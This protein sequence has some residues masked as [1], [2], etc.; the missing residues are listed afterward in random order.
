MSQKI[1]LVFTW[2]NGLDQDWN[3]QRNYY[4][5]LN[6]EKITYY[7]QNSDI[8]YQQIDELNYAIS[9]A[10]KYI[11]W[12][13]NIY[14]VTANQTPDFLD[15][16]NPRIRIVDHTEIIPSEYLPTFSSG[17]IEANIWRISGLSE[18]F[19]YANDDF[20]FLRNVRKSY[21]LTKNNVLRLN[22]QPI[23]LLKLTSSKERTHFQNVIQTE[24]FLKDNEFRSNLYPCHVTQIWRKNTCEYI[25]DNFTD[26]TH[27][28][29]NPKFRTNEQTFWSMIVYNIEATRNKPQIRFSPTYQWVVDSLNSRANAIIGLTLLR[30]FRPPLACINNMPQSVSKILEKKFQYLLN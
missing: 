26:I 20:L 19:L 4:A 9:G 16:T 29:C 22:V 13:G 25:W 18:I 3:D 11:K 2:V 7:D 6:E 10:L 1:D 8:R 30:I 15:L 21:F 14:I 24:I 12:L 17:A 27:K 23:F 28:L 5:E